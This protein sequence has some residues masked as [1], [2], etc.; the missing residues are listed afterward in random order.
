VAS[1]P[2]GAVVAG[3][4]RDEGSFNLNHEAVAALRSL[5]VTTDLRGRF[6]WS[7]AFVG[8]VGA[9]PAAALDAA[10]PIRPAQVTVGLPLAEPGV[11]IVLQRVTIGP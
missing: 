10:D 9:Q 7:H 8:A 3:V 11:G 1:L 2:A 5:G 4:V 6:R